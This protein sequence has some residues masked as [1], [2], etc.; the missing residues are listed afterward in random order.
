MLLIQ[1]KANRK[2]YGCTKILIAVLLVEL[3]GENVHHVALNLKIVLLLFNTMKV[4]KMKKEHQVKLQVG[5]IISSIMQHIAND[6][7]S[8]EF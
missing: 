8:C 1:S 6:H 5:T 4:C 7:F 2:G 3:K